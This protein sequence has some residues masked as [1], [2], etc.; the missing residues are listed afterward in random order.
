MISM[1]PMWNISN[2][3]QMNYWSLEID[4]KMQRDVII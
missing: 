1:S 4:R 3:Q 2:K